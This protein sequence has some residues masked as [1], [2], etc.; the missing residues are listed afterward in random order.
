ML[1][2]QF[3]KLQRYTDTSSIPP[4][5]STLEAEHREKNGSAE[6]QCQNGGHRF[7]Q[8]HSAAVL[9][10]VRPRVR[11]T[12]TGVPPAA[13]CSTAGATTCHVLQLPQEPPALGFWKVSG[14]SRN[15]FVR[16]KFKYQES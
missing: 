8:G 9:G 2:K 16:V 14:N 12:A 6:D 3:L 15:T 4:G 5:S 11:R 7:R 10:I 13:T 1:G